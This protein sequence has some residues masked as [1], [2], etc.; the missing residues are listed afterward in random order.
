MAFPICVP[1]K[2]L[3]NSTLICVFL[4]CEIFTM[5]IDSIYPRSNSHNVRLNRTKCCISPPCISHHMKVSHY[6]K[7]IYTSTRRLLLS[8]HPSRLLGHGLTRR[9]VS[10]QRRVLTSSGHIHWF[11]VSSSSPTSLNEVK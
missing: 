10:K 9:I 5:T 8:K 3:F 6:G 4:S 1:I 11:Y 2:T 7:I